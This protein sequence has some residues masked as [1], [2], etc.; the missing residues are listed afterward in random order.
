[1]N[2]HKNINKDTLDV[3][4][5]NRPHQPVTVQSNELCNLGQK[6]SKTYFWRQTPTS[7]DKLKSRK[8]SGL[9][10]SK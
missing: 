1:M 10:K 3:Y 5:P 4:K 2:S 6:S 7:G 8:R 9:K